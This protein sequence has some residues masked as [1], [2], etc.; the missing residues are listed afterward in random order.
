MWM[1]KDTYKTL[2]L[3]LSLGKKKRRRRRKKKEETGNKGTG[4]QATQEIDHDKMNR[5]FTNDEQGWAN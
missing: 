4:S 1:S 5:A 3:R 2:D